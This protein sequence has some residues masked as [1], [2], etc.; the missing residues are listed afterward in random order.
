MQNK[1]Y[2]KNYSNAELVIPRHIWNDSKVNGIQKMMLALFKRLTKDGTE[3]TRFLSKITAK[4]L[5]T[6]EKDVIY[7]VKQLHS[8]GFIK[9]SQDQQ[10]IWLTYTYKETVKAEPESSSASQLF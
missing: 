5:A 1:I 8:K 3:K 6:H 2:D 10:D 7:N 9:L 4:I